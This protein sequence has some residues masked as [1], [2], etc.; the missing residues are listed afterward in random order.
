[1]AMVRTAEI[2]T[3]DVV[4]PRDI[5]DFLSSAS[6]A[7]RSNY[8]T[9]LKASPG[10]A[11]FGRDMMFDIPYL[12]DWKQIGDK[13]RVD[14]D[15]KVGDEILLRKDGILCKSESPFETKPLT[16]TQVHTNGTVR[17]QHGTSSERFNIRRV[18]PYFK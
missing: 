12:A 5:E 17:A 16:I 6:W 3:A 11:I 8:H 18:T 4:A 1:M 15:Y 14:W 9:V 13:S 7:I 2:D 10:A